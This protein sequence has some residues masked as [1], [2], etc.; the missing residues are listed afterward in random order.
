MPNSG[1]PEQILTST[2]LNVV[3]GFLVGDVVD[4]HDAHGATVV[5]GGDGA[6][7]LL[8]GSVPNLQ[9]D[10]L[11]VHFDGADFEVDSYRRYERGV[12]GVLGESEG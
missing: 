5:G 3:K 9:L 8:A 7:S 1:R 10:L 11:S 4:E 6:E 2:N 12:E